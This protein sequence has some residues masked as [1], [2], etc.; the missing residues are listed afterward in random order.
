MGSILT[1]IKKL[2]GIEESYEHF[3]IDIIIGIN[4]ALSI[5][6]QL[7]VGEKSFSIEDKDA[8]WKDFLSDMTNLELIKSYIHMKVKLLFDPPQSS[9]VIEVMN[10]QIS[11]LE[12]RIN[13][14]VD[15]SKE[16]TSNEETSNE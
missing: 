13:E 6:S 8:E 7:G 16:E 5:L 3:D 9:A 15:P 1:S 2:L 4:T 12:W 11:E 10:R 14:L